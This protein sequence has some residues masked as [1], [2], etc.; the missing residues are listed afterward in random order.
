MLTLKVRLDALE[1]EEDPETG[2]V[3]YRHVA[4]ALASAEFQWQ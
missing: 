4:L 2:T 3:T 1:P